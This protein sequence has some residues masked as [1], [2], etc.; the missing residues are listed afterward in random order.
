MKMSPSSLAQ[1][2]RGSHEFYPE[3][4]LLRSS[5]FQAK[6]DGVEKGDFFEL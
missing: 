6:D 3:A 1:Q 4:K 5:A 2:R